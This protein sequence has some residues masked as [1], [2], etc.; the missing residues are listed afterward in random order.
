[1]E[2]FSQQQTI[3]LDGIR[4]IDHVEAAAV[5]IDMELA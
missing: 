4:E 2:D 1:M 5:I 3:R